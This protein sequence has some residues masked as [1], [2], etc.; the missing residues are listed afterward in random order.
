MSKDNKDEWLHLKAQILDIKAVIKRSPTA[1]E[2]NNIGLEKIYDP[3]SAA[4]FQPLRQNLSEEETTLLQNNLKAEQTKFKNS[5]A[6]IKKSLEKAGLKVKIQHKDYDSPYSISIGLN[7]ALEIGQDD[8]IWG[9]VVEILKQSQINGPAIIPE[10][11][12]PPKEPGQRIGNKLVSEWF[13]LD[14]NLA[15]IVDN[16]KA[17]MNREY[18]NDSWIV[19]LSALREKDIPPL[20]NNLIAA[21]F[22]VGFNSTEN[23]IVIGIGKALEKGKDNFVWGETLQNIAAQRE[24]NM[25]V[26][27]N[28]AAGTAS[29]LKRFRVGSFDQTM[30]D[31]SIQ[32]RSPNSPPPKRNQPTQGAI[33]K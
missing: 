14:P 1:Y 8:R 28:D 13:Q 24:S 4:E 15:P 3:L 25:K 23:T 26:A 21:G 18:N 30:T 17:K 22:N 20:N 9:D 33:S 2:W 12:K 10:V 19:P 16:I 5:A 11:I 32:N 27:L 7:H 29:T 31:S 6:F